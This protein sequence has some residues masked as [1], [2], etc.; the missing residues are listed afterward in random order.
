MHEEASLEWLVDNPPPWEFV[1]EM[2]SLRIQNIEMECEATLPSIFYFTGKE[3]FRYAIAKSTPYKAGR[4]FKPH[5][6]ANIGAFIRESKTCREME[7][8][9][10]DDLLSVDVQAGPNKGRQI[11]CSRDKDL[12]SVTGW[13]Y[14]W[15]LGKQPR[16][17]P[18]YLSGFGALRLSA[19]R[20]K[21]SGYGLKWF[22]AQCLMG[23]STDSIPGLP[24]M[25]PVAAYVCL[26][27]AVEYPEGIR[28][29]RSE[30]L[31][32]GKDEAYLLEQGRLLWMTR[33]LNEDGT[34]VLWNSEE[35]YVS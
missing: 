28:R 2:L 20:K 31:S 22:L 7:L 29:V 14:G 21:L 15:E 30:Y 13:H 33:Q 8:L 23:D 1:E 32:R 18:E 11:I 10:A 16:F 6:H 27:D 12:R 25:G 4:A 24:K 26:S 9:E 3:N 5:H 35:I 19:C 17:G 34:P